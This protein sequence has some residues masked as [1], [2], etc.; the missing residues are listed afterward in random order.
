M[1]S[2]HYK[3]TH[4][5]WDSDL[6]FSINK[7][8]SSPSR[9]P[10]T[11]VCRLMRNFSFSLSFETQMISLSP[12]GTPPTHPPNDVSGSSKWG[13]PVGP[14][15]SRFLFWKR[16]VRPK[17]SA[18]WHKEEKRENPGSLPPSIVYSVYVMTSGMPLKSV[19][20]SSF[21][22]QSEVSQKE[23]HRYSILTHIYG[24]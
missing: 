4:C 24:I 22:L 5:I 8:C 2:I 13:R 16:T 6:Q 9:Y 7:T 14:L 15:G 10:F 3:E 23:K 11:S 17:H 18:N 21:V 1:G 19:E 12:Q 20:T